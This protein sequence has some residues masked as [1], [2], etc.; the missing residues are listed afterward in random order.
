MGHV[1]TINNGYLNL[2]EKIRNIPSFDIGAM[3]Q[4]SLPL[5]MIQ[6]FKTQL[7]IN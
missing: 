4:I 2:N 1:F 6:I 5:P 7:Q 3:S